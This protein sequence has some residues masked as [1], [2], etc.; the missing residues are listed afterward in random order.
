M[1]QISAG[2]NNIIKAARTLDKTSLFIMKNVAIE[3]S[4]TRK[5]TQEIMHNKND[6]PS[7]SHSCRKLIYCVIAAPY[8]LLSIVANDMR[9][10]C[11]IP[12]TTLYVNINTALIE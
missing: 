2:I 8:C 11:D 12:Q 1:R 3:N 10:I 4:F 5:A 7:S 9:F 6:L